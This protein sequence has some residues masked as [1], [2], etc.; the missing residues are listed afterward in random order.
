M[1]VFSDTAYAKINLALHVRN[2]REDGYHE[3]E[4][5]FGFVDAG[6]CL[7]VSPADQI[8]LSI[9]GPFEQ[10]L[11]ESDDNLILK[12]ARLLQKQFDVGAGAHLTLEKNLPVASG[13]GGGSAD[14][15]AAARLL[16]RL[17]N[18]N[19]SDEQLAHILSK[20]GAD[21][22]ACISSRTALG[23]GTGTELS[24]LEKPDISG[25]PVLLVN[26]L[27]RVST[28]EVFHRWNG[29]DLG[30]LQS[31][32]ALEMTQ[33]GRNDLEAAAMEICPDISDVLAALG[34]T[35]AQ[36]ARMSGSGATCFALYQ[37]KDAC[38]T[39]RNM[40]PPNWWILE[41]VLR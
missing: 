16:N 23:R 27:K 35:G 17:W 31:G 19:A 26:P 7:T 37:S 39:A 8:S 1:P 32:S 30:A 15:A 25:V 28:G 3:L 21:I 40:M 13:I 38:R 41:G 36:I 4:T 34:R 18:L 5:L 9:S 2:R 10:D 6:D 12:T 11:D 20:L 24:M 33:W 29:S 22:P 14:A